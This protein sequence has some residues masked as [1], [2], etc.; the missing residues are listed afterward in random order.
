MNFL[1]IHALAS[2]T[3]KLYLTMLH[4]QRSANLT[5]QT[6]EVEFRE[7]GYRANNQFHKLPK[8]VRFGFLKDAKGPP[9]APTKIITKAITFTKG[10]AT[11]YPD[12]KISAG[13]IYLVDRENKFMYAVTVPISEIP[14]IRKYKYKDN[15]WAQMQ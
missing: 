6:K 13:T 2:E 8:N 1:N 3:E 14:H 4:Q 5:N 7:D 11:F 15:I 9:S 12:N 10:S